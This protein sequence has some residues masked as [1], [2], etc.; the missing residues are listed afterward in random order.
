GE[1]HFIT[2]GPPIVKKDFKGSPHGNP[3]T[4]CETFANDLA[5]TSAF[6]QIG[7]E[8]AQS[9]RRRQRNQP[10]QQAGPTNPE[11]FPQPPSISF[12]PMPKEFVN[13]VP[14]DG[15]LVG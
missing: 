9:N 6:H 10:N 13:R 7:E 11:Q 4:D 5:N 1:P 15:C 12:R 3:P 14:Q 8:I 2:N